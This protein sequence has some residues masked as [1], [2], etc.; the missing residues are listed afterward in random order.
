MRGTLLT[1]PVLAIAVAA[2]L[3]TGASAAGAPG[4]ASTTVTIQAEGTDLSGVVTSPRPK[5]CAA[6]RVV[7]VVRQKGARGGGDDVRFATDTASLEG[8]VYRW[9]TG[10]TGT[11]GRFYARVRHVIGCKADTSPTIRA[12][13]NP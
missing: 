13:R 2:G 5:R 3:G 11:E 4:D 1:V 9:S 12:T 10:N 8:G 7:V 6:D